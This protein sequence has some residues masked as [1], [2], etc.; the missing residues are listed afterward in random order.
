MC[1]E[2][3]FIDGLCISKSTPLKGKSCKI[4]YSTNVEKKIC[5]LCS[6]REYVNGQCIMKECPEKT[7]RIENGDCDYSA[8]NIAGPLFYSMDMTDMDLTEREIPSRKVE[9]YPQDAFES[10]PTLFDENSDHFGK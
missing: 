8:P 9:E 6:N 3:V 2:R 7:H 4:L 10:I 5:D 1:P